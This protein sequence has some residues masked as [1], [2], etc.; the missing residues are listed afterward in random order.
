[1]IL[2]IGDLIGTSTVVVLC[3]IGYGYRKYGRVEWASL[4]LAAVAI[5]SWQL[6]KQ[7]VLAIV[8][9]IIADAM[10]AMPTLV[11]SY[12]DPW[13]EHPAAWLIIAI[14]A[15]CGVFSSTIFNAANLL[16]PAYLLVVNGTIGTF[17]LIGRHLKEKP[18]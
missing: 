2:L 9:S 3:L 10:A 11:K 18:A 8:F 4:A 14:G 16:F 5:I 1:M 7:P 6:T 15:L 17:A 13:S 12:R